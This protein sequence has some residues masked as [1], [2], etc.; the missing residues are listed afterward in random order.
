MLQLCNYITLL[1]SNVISLWSY[2]IVMHLH[3][4]NVSTSHYNN[5]T[6]MADKFKIFVNNSKNVIHL[7]NSNMTAK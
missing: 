7:Q 5:I 6:N 2:N 1:Y 4:S 3:Y